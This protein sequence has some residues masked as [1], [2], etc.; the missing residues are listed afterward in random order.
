V[1]VATAQN[2]LRGCLLDLNAA[3]GGLLNITNL[4]TPQGQMATSLTELIA[5]S[6]SFWVWLV[7][8]IDPATASGVMQEAIGRIYFITR[9]PATSTIVLAT[10][11]GAVG[12]VITQGSQAKDTAGN[13]Y[14]ALSTVTI[15]SDGTADVSFSN[16]VTGPIPCLTGTLTSITT[17]TPGWDS[18]TNAADG[19][20]G[21]NIETRAEFE[22]RRSQSVAGNSAGQLASIYSAIASITGVRDIF[23]IEN[24][25]GSAVDV[26]STDYEV[27]AHSVYVAVL[28]GTDSAIGA[29]IYNKKSGGCNMNGDTTVNVIDPITGTSNEVTF[30]RPAAL[31]IKFAVEIVDDPALPS[32]IVQ[33]IKN[34]ISAAFNGTNFQGIGKPVFA[35]RYYQTV[36][37]VNE[38]VELL[39]VLVGTSTATLTS[40]AVGIDQYPTITGSNITV[41]LI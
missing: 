24:V 35:S 11:T 32:D 36:I 20:L 25:T 3:F 31:P 2:I 22:A 5:Q 13:I 40:V 15:P 28:G 9:K 16:I 30:E 27:A 7:A 4:G 1:I 34:A 21:T 8:N 23:I 6:Q 41:T 26:G 29:A 37:S 17:V 14:T 39:S 18:I 19:T 38:N 12:T 10:C 33:L